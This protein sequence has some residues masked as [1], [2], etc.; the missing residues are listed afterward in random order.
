M[1]P[2]PTAGGTAEAGIGAARDAGAGWT[3][4]TMTVRRPAA[5][6]RHVVRAPGIPP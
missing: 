5:F 4:V 3:G 6:P 1:R 2:W